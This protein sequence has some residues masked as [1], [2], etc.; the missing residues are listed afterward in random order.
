MNRF[1]KNLK[2]LPRWI[3]ILIDM[4]LFLFAVSLGY[5]L[6]FNFDLA[7]IEANNYEVGIMLFVGAGLVS[8]LATGSYSGIIRYTGFEDAFRIIIMVTIA[9]AICAVANFTNHYLIGTYIIPFST[10]VIAWMASAIFLISYRML[11]KIVFSYYTRSSIRYS[12]ALIFGAGKSGQITRQIFENAPNSSVRIIGYL[13]DDFNK[14]GKVLN[15]VKIYPANGN[16][17]SLIESL[18]IKEMIISVQNLSVTRKSELVDTCIKL[19]V[20]VKHVP[21]VYRWT[22]GE[23]SAGQIKE[24]KIEDLLGR[25]SIKLN[26]YYVNKELKNKRIF[27]TG[28]AGSIG[29][30]LVRQVALYSPSMIIL[31]DQWESGLFD[32]ENELFRSNPDCVIY[33]KILDITNERRL[34][35][36]FSEF[37]PDIVYHAAAYKHVP[38]MESN[39]SEAILCNVGG[40]KFM[41]DLSVEFEVEKFVMVSTDKAVNPTNVM[42]ASKRIAEIYC[43]S[44]SKHQNTTNFIT[45]R[46]G[47]VLGSNGSVI[48]RFRKQIENGGPVTVTDPEVS[49]Y[50]MTIPEACQLVL[51]AGAIGKGGEIYIFDMGESIKID[52]L[53]KKMIKL[54]KLKLNK[55][56]QL[57]YTGLR[58]GEKL[59]EE[60]LNTGEDTLPTH[61]PKIMIAK[62]KEYEWD[63][64]SKSTQAL[65][66][67]FDSQDNDAIVSSMKK[68]IPEFQSS[69]SEFEKLDSKVDV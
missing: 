34:S 60:L 1:I 26:N 7:S 65:I 25:E 40:T 28:A 56:I 52:H 50:F 27:I 63:I 48:L 3:I 21:P 55:D 2:I 16:L 62:V 6:R 67:L 30:E 22:R 59:V 49:R 68:M 11:V 12:N 57:I 46:F 20:K 43:Q 53:A 47:N 33:S 32:I 9:A 64:V 38:L 66:D 18:N 58:K 41:A 45:T 15:G 61:H 19:G 35:A 17:V 10:L 24:V 39:P 13:E 54:S 42:G 4:G 14:V 37:K 51:E 23:L 8:T 36:I 29:S 69:N 5:L 31:L 44:L